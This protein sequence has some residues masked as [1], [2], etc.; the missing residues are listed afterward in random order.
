MIEVMSGLTFILILFTFPMNGSSQSC[1]GFR[2]VK[3][4]KGRKETEFLKILANRG[5]A[6]KY[7]CATCTKKVTLEK[8]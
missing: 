3:K 1:L 8:K 2:K 7:L 4:I 6:T 5:N